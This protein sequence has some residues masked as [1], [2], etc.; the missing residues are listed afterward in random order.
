L[1]R[2]QTSIIFQ[3]RTGHTSLK[4]HL[5]RLHKADSPNC[6][7]CE[8]QRICIKETVKH[9]IMD[10]PAYRR[11]RFQLLRKLGRNARSLCHILSNEKAIPHLLQYIGRTK[12]FQRVIGDL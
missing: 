10:C 4:A 12:R 2:K 9:Y 5:H 6:P 7:H 11:E 3:L 1:K 8:R